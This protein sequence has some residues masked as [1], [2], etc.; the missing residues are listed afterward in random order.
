MLFGVPVWWVLARFLP[1][2]W[3]GN[4]RKR[5]QNVPGRVPQRLG[6]VAL[7]GTPEK[8]IIPVKNPNR[9]GLVFLVRTY[10]EPMV[11]F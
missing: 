6:Y 2:D 3:S 8:G 11:T 5:Y 4:V 1:S 7:Q 10:V 9:K